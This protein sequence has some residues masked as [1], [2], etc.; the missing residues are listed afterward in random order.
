MSTTLLSKFMHSVCVSMTFTHTTHTRARLS[1]R[2]IKCTVCI[3]ILHCA[4]APTHSMFVFYKEWD[5]SSA[6]C[7]LHF[8]MPPLHVYESRTKMSFAMSFELNDRVEDLLRPPLQLHHELTPIIFYF[9]KQTLCYIFFLKICIPYIYIY[10]MYL[11]YLIL[12]TNPIF[13]FWW[14]KTTSHVRHCGSQRPSLFL[15]LLCMSEKQRAWARMKSIQHPISRTHTHTLP[16][17][18]HTL[19]YIQYK[20]H[21]RSTRALLLPC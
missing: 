7:Q 19:S 14:F 8:V 2:W 20:T 4:P 9:L 1:A 6:R 13:F 16:P 3:S 5:S 15:P 18:H 11:M 21:T 17:S 12:C 10:L